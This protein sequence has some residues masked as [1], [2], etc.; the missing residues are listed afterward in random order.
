MDTRIGYKICLELSDIHI[1]GT[2]ETER[3]SDGRYDL[4]KEPV[5]VGVGGSLDI[6]VPSA[7]IVDSFVVNH[8]S[9]V[10]MLK[11]GMGGQDRVVGF[12]N[13]S[14]DLR[15]WVD[16]KFKLRLLS[17]VN[18]ETLHEQRSKSRASATTKGMKDEESLKAGALVSKFADS[19]QNKVNN[20]FANGVMSTS[21]VVRSVFFASDKLFWVKEL[22]ICPS[23]N[24]ICIRECIIA[25]CVYSKASYRLLL[26]PNLQKLLGEHVFQLQSH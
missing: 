4:S 13:S 20:L 10:G 18:G 7:D 19:V 22:T 16:S 23:A 9:T 17:I 25:S 24:L 12:N 14:R 6:E 5:K 2:I 21:I 8:E 1:Q 3:G 26:A 11:G 15:G